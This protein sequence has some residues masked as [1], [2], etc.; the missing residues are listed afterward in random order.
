MLT[1]HSGRFIVDNFKQAKVL[2]VEL[3]EEVKNAMQTLNITSSDTFYEW[4]NEERAYLKSL[5]EDPPLDLLKI[6]YLGLLR[7]LTKAK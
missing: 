1:F 4:I 2:I 7:Q 3:T 5:P 6:E